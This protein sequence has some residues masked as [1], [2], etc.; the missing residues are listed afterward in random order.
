MEKI[1][2]Y[3]GIKMY[4]VPHAKEIMEEVIE[5]DCYR[6]NDIPWMSL[7]FDIGGFYGEFGIMCEKKQNC[8]VI[9]FEPC[10]ANREISEANIKLN[11]CGMIVYPEAITDQNTT[12]PFLYNNTHPGGSGLCD[13]SHSTDIVSTININ[14][15]LHQD[16]TAIFAA[17]EDK[18]KITVK[19]DAEG[20]EV[21]MFKN[22]DWLNYV[23]YLTMEWHHFD[24]H[25]YRNIL[26]KYGFEVELEGAGP[27]PRP[28]Y[29][30]LIAG[31]LLHAK[32]N[33]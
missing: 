15:L 10:A 20:S 26:E 27:P 16:S 13:K 14:Y 24:G 9:M 29:N 1:I 12:S 17:K 6:I 21:W 8:N 31:G 3:H 22:S 33:E 32:K 5:H 4:D 18:R 30:N 2:E 19:I 7:V 23:D 25:V 28:R 11:G